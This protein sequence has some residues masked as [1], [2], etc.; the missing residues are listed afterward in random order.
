MEN[1]VES[2]KMFVDKEAY[3]LLNISFKEITGET[4]ELLMSIWFPNLML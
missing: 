3:F 1:K 2:L 4:N